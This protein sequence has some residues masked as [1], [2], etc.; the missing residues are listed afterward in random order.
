MNQYNKNPKFY[1][2][3]CDE[4]KNICS[5]KVI[6]RREYASWYYRK[7]YANNNP[8]WIDIKFKKGKFNIDVSSN[9]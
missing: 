5:N 1:C 4:E 8:E 2:S 7:Q 6:H 3:C 9:A